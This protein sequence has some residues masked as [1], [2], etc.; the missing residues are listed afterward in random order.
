MCCVKTDAKSHLMCYGAKSFLNALFQFFN[1]CLVMFCNLSFDV[2]PQS[3]VTSG[4]VRTALWPQKYWRRP[5]NPT[6]VGKNLIE[7]ISYHKCMMCR[8]PILLE[9]MYYLYYLKQKKTT[10]PWYKQILNKQLKPCPGT[11]DSP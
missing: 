10:N 2:P 4:Q 8:C 11:Y 6:T 9:I 7:V 5:S 3:I 1:R